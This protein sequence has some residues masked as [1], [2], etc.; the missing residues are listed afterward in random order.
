MFYRVQHHS[1][2]PFDEFDL[3]SSDVFDHVW[4]TVC[5]WVNSSL[6]IKPRFFGQ[7]VIRRFETNADNST[8]FQFVHELF[9]CVSGTEY[10]PSYFRVGE[11]DD[12]VACLAT[13]F[14]RHN[15]TSSH[16]YFKTPNMTKAVAISPNL[17]L[18]NQVVFPGGNAEKCG[19]KYQEIHTNSFHHIISDIIGKKNENIDTS[20]KCHQSKAWYSHLD[21]SSRLFWYIIPQSTESTFP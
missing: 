17:D 20:E 4:I 18:Y 19:R 9:V 5:L 21:L 16:V 7:Q 1:D 3:G 6:W 15:A 8:L 10:E 13:G 11:A 2:Y 14:S 12:D